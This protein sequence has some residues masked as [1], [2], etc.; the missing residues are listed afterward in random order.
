MIQA[1][2]APKRSWLV[3]EVIQT[4]GMDCGPASLKCLLEGFGVPVSYGRL[5]EACQTDVDGTSIDTLEEVANQLGLVAEQVMLPVDHLLLP[6]AE[7]LPAL[8][9]VRL[10][11][12]LTHFVVVWRRWGRWVQVMDPGTGRRW[13][14]GQRFLSELYVHAMPVPAV[15]W[16][17]WAAS[18]DF[19]T[20]LRRRLSDLGQG[21]A[22]TGTLID[23]ALADPGWTSLAA[24][25]AATR[26]VT[27]I[28]RSGGLRRGQQAG[29]ALT[30]FFQQAQTDYTDHSPVPETYWSVRP[31]DPNPD[32]EEQL[33]LRG[34]VL[35][36]VPGRHTHQPEPLGAEDVTPLPAQTGL[37]PDLV[38]ALEESPQRPG[39]ELLGF[40][41]VDGVL[42]P[43]VLLL[44]LLLAAGSLV[45]EAML[46]RGLFDLSALLGAGNQ[47]L[48][49]VGAI[50][51]FIVALLLMRLQII[52]TAL[53]LGRG[54]ETRLRVAFLAKI[55]R[56][57]DR[58]FQ[59]RLMSDMAERS[60]SVH[61][62][63]LLPM[64]GAN[65]IQQTFTL[66]L[67]VVGIIWL[68]PFSASLG[69]LERVGGRRVAVAGPISPQRA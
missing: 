5:R 31:A 22:V 52:G 59:S 11:D 61:Q 34:A 69:Y 3:P 35:L 26:M 30:T 1:K 27:T 55:P 28:V 40:L 39:R 44:A 41:R 66:I 18:D 65:L 54:L 25:D 6:E 24:L 33:M 4:S 43:L 48:G 19:L 21:K 51:F 49:I 42:T 38:G 62:L 64:L 10:P 15:V 23:T 57:H 9:V 29:R 56:L 68:D 47:R 46:F 17:D 37:T 16:R 63:R 13:M 45:V 2:T 20:P 50:L 12:G 14:S 60:H 32:G 8:V 53:R 36:Q 7:A 67:T 58:Y